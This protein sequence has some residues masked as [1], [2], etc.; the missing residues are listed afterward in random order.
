MTP[1]H[2]EVSITISE[3]VPL[4][5]QRYRHTAIVFREKYPC[6]PNNPLPL[7]IHMIGGSGFFELQHSDSLDPQSEKT[8]LKEIPVGVLKGETSTLPRL[9]AL[10]KRVP[11]ENWDI[12]FNCQ[13]WVERA[14]VR[15]RDAGL[16]GAREC[17]EGVEAMVEATMNGAADM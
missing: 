9:L 13:T 5:W 11:I 7:V 2:H 3:G 10:L 15:L 17:E 4:D 14:L 12:E 16:L 1:S 8:F 6:T